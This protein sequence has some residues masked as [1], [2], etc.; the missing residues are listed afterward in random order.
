MAST[1]VVTWARRI[2]LAV[3]LLLAAL[4]VLTLFDTSEAFRNKV[5]WLLAEFAGAVVAALF[6]AFL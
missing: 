3:A 4:G 6:Y 2:A 1:L 5:P